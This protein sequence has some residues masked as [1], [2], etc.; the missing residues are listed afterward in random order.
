MV[1]IAERLQLHQGGF[2]VG[3]AFCVLQRLLELGHL[4]AQGL[5][6]HL[7]GFVF[8]ENVLQGLGGRVGGLLQLVHGL[9]VGSLLHEV[10]HQQQEKS[11]CKEDDQIEQYRAALV[12]PLML[13]LVLEAAALLLVGI[14]AQRE[15]PPF[16]AEGSC[17]SSSSRVFK[18]S[19]L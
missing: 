19:G 3:G 6:F 10:G 8:L 9:L 5:V 2:V 18:S 14:G 4:L 1:Q 7:E 15:P 11:R 12:G 17:S 13:R 16:P